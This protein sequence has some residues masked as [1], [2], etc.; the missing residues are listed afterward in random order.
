MPGM[1]APVERASK[2]TLK[3]QNEKGEN[4]SLKAEGLL[5]TALQHEYDH[6]EG[7]LFIDR[8]KDPEDIKFVPPIIEPREEQL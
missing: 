5:A 6:L 1:E 3:C 4:I 7:K 2:I 8:V